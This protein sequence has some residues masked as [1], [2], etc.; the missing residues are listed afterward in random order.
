[1]PGPLPFGVEGVGHLRHGEGQESV[2]IF[3][4][5]NESALARVTLLGCEAILIL[6]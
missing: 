6:H 1:M 4:L 2:T 3:V 5:L